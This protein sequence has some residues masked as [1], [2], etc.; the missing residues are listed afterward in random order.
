MTGSVSAPHESHWCDSPW[1][2]GATVEERVKRCTS[3]LLTAGVIAHSTTQ[4]SGHSG[5]RPKQAGQAS[6]DVGI[7][8][9][10]GASCRPRCVTHP[11]VADVTVGDERVVLL[12]L[13]LLHDAVINQLGGR[14]LAGAGARGH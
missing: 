9:C 8:I 3:R 11:G 14:L 4:C 10:K 5:A 6:M 2:G 1:A 12:G 7:H 13:H